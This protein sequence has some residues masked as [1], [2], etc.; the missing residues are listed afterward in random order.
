MV[1]KGLA[2]GAALVAVLGSAGLAQS[3]PVPP[4]SCPSVAPSDPESLLA[5]GR[6]WHAARAAPPLPAAPRPVPAA[7]AERHLAIAAALGDGSRTDG[8]VARVRGADTI[9]AL[10]LLAA[11][12]DEQAGRWATAE[13]RY[14]RVAALPAA[15]PADRAAAAVRLAVALEHQGTPG[16]AA[17]AWRRAAQALPQLEDWFALRRAALEPDTALAFATLAAMRS[18]GAAAGADALLAGRRLAAGNL[19]GALALYLR[20]GRPLDAARVEVALGRGDVARR[21]VDRVLT[22]DPAQPIA[23]LAANFLVA[24]FRPLTPVELLGIARAYRARGG[25]ATAEGYARRAAAGDSGIGGW[26]EVAF[27]AAARRRPLEARV[28]L[29][30]AAARLARRPGPAATALA[31]VRVRVLAAAGRWDEADSVVAG[32]A[33]ASPGDSSA[34]A[35]ALYLADRARVRGA[36]ATER[37]LESL[38]VRD[39]GG[40]AAGSIARFRLALASYAA[41]RRDSAASA[42]ATVLARD[43]AG[44]LGLAARYWA[45]RIALERGDAAG[46]AA[47]RAVAAAA[48]TRYYGVRAREL[49][50][51]PLALAPDSAPAG[52]GPGL[53]PGAAAERVGLLAAVGLTAEARAEALGWVADSAAPAAVLAAAGTAAAAADFGREAVLLG[54]AARVRGP[55]SRATAEAFF[56]RPFRGVVAGEAAEACVDPL[57]LNAIIRQESR[58][59]PLAR[60]R[61]GARGLAQMEQRT[62][63]EMTR[64]MRLGSWNP[65]LLDV[66]DFN[67]HLGARYLRDRMARGPLPLPALIA[68]FNAGPARIAQWRAWPELRDPDLFV[69][70]L[71]VSETRDY[72]RNVYANYAW[73]RRLYAAAGS[74]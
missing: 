46:P 21:R 1:G 55:L 65:Q 63:R 28:A 41:G 9:P 33:R 40:T 39:F 34:A 37:A 70:R 18:P 44:E 31:P 38:L 60:S 19:A 66:P 64:R 12:S 24:T 57:L 13:A 6:Y 36:D 8:I 22:A 59:Q 7:A 25:L 54:D 30:S 32:M 5:A 68:S 69:E 10:L 52:R 73:Y 4:E 17:D 49:L 15:S 29:D 42:L 47:L 2:L 11:R 53:D 48:P 67:L 72:V 50:G 56:P 20:R 27:V 62:A 16:A 23:L 61:A 71:S 51:E 45:G 43:S 35:A 74:P 14:R 26:L 3:P 58:F